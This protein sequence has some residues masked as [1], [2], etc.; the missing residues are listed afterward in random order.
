MATTDQLALYRD[1][2]HGFAIP[3]PRT[4]LMRKNPQESIAVIFVAPPEHDD[5]RPNVVVTVDDLESGQTLESWQDFVDSVSPRMLDQYV[6]LDN[7][8]IERNGRRVHRRLA[9]H[10]NAEGTAL[11]MEQWATVRGNVGYTVTTTAETMELHDS[12]ALFAAIAR[13]F[14]LDGDEQGADA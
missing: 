5:F 12:A 3:A 9:H 13:G 8:N 1:P 7:E 6:V 11:T 14:H 2:D 4:W 10:M